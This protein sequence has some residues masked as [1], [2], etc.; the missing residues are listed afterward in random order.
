MA[1][2]MG[3]PRWEGKCPRTY[4][5]TR[6]TMYNN[7]WVIKLGCIGNVAIINGNKEYIPVRAGK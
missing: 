4:N 6:G 5:P 2:Q 1:P 7:T 3:S